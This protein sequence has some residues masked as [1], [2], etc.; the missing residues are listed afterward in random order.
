MLLLVELMVFFYLKSVE[1]SLQV[2]VLS[3]TLIIMGRYKNILEYLP[4]RLLIL[5][6]FVQEISWCLLSR[7]K[8]W[9]YKQGFFLS[10]GD[11]NDRDAK[12]R[13]AYLQV[14]VAKRPNIQFLGFLESLN[15]QLRR[16]LPHYLRSWLLSAVVVQLV[17]LEK[18]LSRFNQRFQLISLVRGKLSAHFQ[19]LHGRHSLFLRSL[20]LSALL[21]IRSAV[22]WDIGVFGSP[23][24]AWLSRR[25]HPAFTLAK[26][27]STLRGLHL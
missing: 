9:W 18:P 21:Q 5:L 14:Q 17:L 11:L 12:L 26:G 22:S 3:G 23:M 24:G 8:A 25:P 20:V 7:A 16:R 10:L 6:Y 1:I 27:K 15:H 2:V 4:A 19:A 13:R